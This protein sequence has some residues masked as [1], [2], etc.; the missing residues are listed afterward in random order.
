MAENDLFRFLFFRKRKFP[1]QFYVMFKGRKFLNFHKFPPLLWNNHYN[2]PSGKFFLLPPVVMEDVAGE[3]PLIVLRVFGKR[4]MSREFPQEEGN[5]RKDNRPFVNRGDMIEIERYLFQV[6]S[7]FWN[8]E[9]IELA[10]L[11][12]EDF[13][14][15]R[16]EGVRSVDDEN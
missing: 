15:L 11:S 10:N 8:L 6:P 16:K 4:G 7:L 5:G 2:L 9:R 3:Q 1:E 12:G 13:L 14:L